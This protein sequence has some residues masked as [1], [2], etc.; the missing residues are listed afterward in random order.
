VSTGVDALPATE[1]YRAYLA[2]RTDL[3]QAFA[4]DGLDRL[5]VPVWNASAWGSPT[6]HGVGY[7]ETE[8]EAER[9]AFGEAVETLAAARWAAA[10]RVVELTVA[11]AAREGGVHPADLSLPVGVSVA[12]DDRLLWVEGFTWPGR[13]RRLLPLEAVVTS[14]AE[15]ALAA[16]DGRE[17]LFPPITNG[18]GA[19]AGDDLARAVRHGVLELLQRD[20]NWAE[21][22]ALDTGR[23][24]AAAAVA[25]D[26]VARL[27]AA[28]VEPV[29]KWSGTA[30]GV[31]AF[32]CAMVDHD[33][34]LAAVARTA[35]GEGAGEDPRAAAR[36]ALLECCSSR[37]RK[38]FFFGGADALAVAPA[39]YRERAAA[40]VNRTERERGWSIVERFDA[41]LGDPATLDRVVSTITRVR[42]TVPLPE[43]TGSLDL[44]G[45]EVVVVRL[46]D[47]D[48]EAQVARVTVPGLEAEVLS[49]H[50]VGPR[51]L[52][53]L[54]ERLPEAVR[55]DGTIAV[56]PLERLAADF[57]PLY[58]EPDRHGYPSP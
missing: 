23:A 58:R 31:H 49:H 6:A 41:L 43:R 53:R 42:E 22:K 30:F 10:A 46:T 51:A 18:L 12:P 35:T 17:P 26:L 45:R 15:F 13:E 14:P 3:V 50:R 34:A 32:H 5:G 29:V 25:P 1:A 24:V 36:K 55:D 52:A 4:I 16:G 11:A 57:L 37:S 7:G 38:R 47:A 39:A 48:D 9:G 8:A 21:F 33:P 2:S 56:R 27:R 54:C 20:L 28:G 44:G 19:G 40:L